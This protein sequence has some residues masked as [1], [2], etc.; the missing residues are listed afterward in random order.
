MLTL[1]KKQRNQLFPEMETTNNNEII[2]KKPSISSNFTMM[3]IIIAVGTHSV[4]KRDIFEVDGGI[5]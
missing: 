3:V 2:P 4:P 1:T 5:G